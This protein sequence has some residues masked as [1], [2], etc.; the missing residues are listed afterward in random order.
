[1]NYEP[2]D[3]HIHG[4]PALDS[5]GEQRLLWVIG[6]VRTDAVDHLAKM[7]VPTA[8]DFWVLHPLPKRAQD[9]REGCM[10]ELASELAK[11]SIVCMLLVR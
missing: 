5:A 10:E 9:V 8:N 7:T 2:R 11:V 6:D 3:R 1:M 4:T